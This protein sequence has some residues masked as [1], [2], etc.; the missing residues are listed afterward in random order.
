MRS[1]NFKYDPARMCPCFQV[2]TAENS[3]KKKKKS[4]QVVIIMSTRVCMFIILVSAYKTVDTCPSNCSLLSFQNRK[5][6]GKKRRLNACW[7]E[8]EREHGTLNK[9][10]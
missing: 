2:H 5:K 6:R 4:A 1:A 8:A 10:K 7:P 9:K 3:K